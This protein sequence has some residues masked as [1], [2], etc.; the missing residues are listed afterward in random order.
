MLYQKEEILEINELNFQL[1]KLE[2][3]E[4]INHKVRTEINET[5]N[6]QEH[7]VL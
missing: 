4:H 5:K 6:I 2:K 3:E 7:V 1:K